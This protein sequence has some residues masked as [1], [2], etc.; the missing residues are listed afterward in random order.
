VKRWPAVVIVGLVLALMGAAMAEEAEK[1]SVRVIDVA[2]F[3]HGYGFV[4]AEGR[5]QPAA[6][7]VTFDKVPQA[8]LGT[9]WL[10]SP[11]D[12]V[13]VDR[14]VAEVKDLAEPE[15]VSNLDDLILANIGKKVTI[16]GPDEEKWSGV[17][18]EPLATEGSSTGN[19]DDETIWAAV[20]PR[21]H[22]GRKQVSHAVLEQSNGKQIVIPKSMMRTIAFDDSPARTVTI[23]RPEQVLSARLV[24]GGK[25]VVSRSNVGM[26]YMAKGLQWVPSYR[27][28]LGETKGDARLRLQATVIN[29]A[30]EL[31]NSNLHLVVGVPHFIQ[32]EE[33]SPL[34]LQM[35]WT[36]LSGYFAEWQR[37]QA[38]VYSNVRMSQVARPIAVSGPG[39]YGGYGGYGGAMPGMVSGEAM[40]VPQVAGL[41]A[42]ELFFYHVPEMTLA[43]GGRAAV[44]IFDEAVKYED[45]YLLNM[46]DEPGTA[47]RRYSAQYTRERGGSRD[48]EAEALARELA[49]PRAWHALRIKNETEQPWTTGAL[50]TVKGWRPIAQSMLTYTAIGAQVDVRTTIAPDIGVRR[51]DNE[52]ARQQKAYHVS[53]WDYDLVT[54]T[55]EIKIT[56]H[57]QE[58]IRLI[59]TRRIE[60]EVSEATDS[61]EF[62]KL[63]E[64]SFG[65][66]PASQ[67]KWDVKL[68]AGEE[69]TLTY[70]YSVYVRV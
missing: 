27:L 17:L 3:K 30:V 56:N 63:G 39:G 37:R 29:D 68:G 11:D 23:T 25:T 12:G 69:K 62:A 49:R 38:D 65:I 54:V 50:L 6:G 36:G 45:V 10:Y 55:G 57:K 2:V 9:L 64:E 51:A 44:G 67:I 66:N 43:K 8:S 32:Q 53:G 47:H 4:M 7:W 41:G 59:A 31:D 42:E 28:E 1:T 22:P 33:I 19:R 21:E 24:K 26:A 70:V 40:P 13:T 61:A 14:S 20:P 60:G 58:E 16:Y 35:A 48:D 5:G 18:V 46:T 34:S 15:D 52:T